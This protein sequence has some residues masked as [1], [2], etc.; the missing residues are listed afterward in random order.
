MSIHCPKCHAS[1]THLEAREVYGRQ[2]IRC[3]RCGFFT[4]RS[5]RR[6]RSSRRPD[7]YTDLKRIM[8]R[9]GRFTFQDL[10]DRSMLTGAQISGMINGMAL[11]GRV[12]ERIDLGGDQV[13][14]RWI[15]GARHDAA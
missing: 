3:L 5:L 9:L 2:E 7:D 11:N 10:C 1:K 4:G 6:R 15:G 12:I 14:Y 13:A 8:K